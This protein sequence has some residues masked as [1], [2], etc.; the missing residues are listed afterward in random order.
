MKTLPEVMKYRGQLASIYRM[1]LKDVSES[2]RC[3]EERWGRE[4]RARGMDGEGAER[5]L[6]S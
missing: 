3:I 2:L 4:L 5:L 1:Q 6:W